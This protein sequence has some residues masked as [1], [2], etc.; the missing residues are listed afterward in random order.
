M[1]VAGPPL[2]GIG[3]HQVHQF[4]DGRL[5]RC[6]LQFGEVHLLLFGLQFDIGIR[7]VGHRLHDLLEVFF[8][9]GAVGLLDT[10]LNRTF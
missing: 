6:L 5:I 10:F 8:L 2:H 9:G 1:N 7:D 3:Q 4:D